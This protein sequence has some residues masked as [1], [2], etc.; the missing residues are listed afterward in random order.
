[1]HLDKWWTLKRRYIHTWWEWQHTHEIASY[2]QCEGQFG[3]AYTAR[4]FTMISTFL[5]IV[6]FYMLQEHFGILCIFPFAVYAYIFDFD[7][8]PWAVPARWYVLYDVNHWIPINSIRWYQMAVDIWRGCESKLTAPVKSKFIS[9]V[10]TWWLWVAWHQWVAWWLCP[11]AV[12]AVQPWA[13]QWPWFQ[14]LLKILESGRWELRPSCHLLVINFK[15]PCFSHGCRHR[16][17]SGSV[18]TLRYKYELYIYISF[19]LVLA[20]LFYTCC[21]EGLGEELLH[22]GAKKRVRLNSWVV[23]LQ[24]IV[25]CM[26]D[27][28]YQ[29]TLCLNHDIKWHK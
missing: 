16:I 3:V 20:A 24:E 2:S 5:F 18:T 9:E 23:G 14:W 22:V 25:V 28:Y 26:Q 19:Y 6:M 13:V 1:M 15:F 27:T 10:W 29:I 4:R 12:A 11:W 8:D 17:F 7:G 21:L